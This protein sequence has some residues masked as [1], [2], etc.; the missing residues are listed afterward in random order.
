[1]KIDLAT[2]TNADMLSTINQ[3]FEDIE[4][5][6]QNNVLYR[7]NPPGETN[8]VNNDLDV[9]GS[10]VFNVDNI[11][12]QSLTLGGVDIDS[13]DFE[14]LVTT[15]AQNLRVTSGPITPI[16][17]D[18]NGKF[19]SFDPT[20]NP[21]LSS[22]TG[23]DPA[24][25]ADLATS[26]GGSNVGF[27]QT[28][29]GAVAR[30]VLSKEK[31]VVSVKDFGAVG[32]NVANDSTA[33]TDATAN[34]DVVIVPTGTYKYTADYFS[35]ENLSSAPASAVLK[36]TIINDAFVRGRDSKAIGVK[37]N[38]RLDLTYTGA[39]PR[40]VVATQI[41]SGRM[42]PAPVSMA[43]PAGSIDLMVHWYGDWGLDWYRQ[44]TGIGSKPFD[45]WYDGSWNWDTN[46]TS[47]PE[48]G[49][50]DPQ[51]ASVMGHY[52]NDDR[53]ALEWQAYWLREA[54]IKVVCPVS[55]NLVPSTFFN[56]NDRDY[57]IWNL[58]ETNNMKGMSYI[59][60]G[61]TTDF[62]DPDGPVTASIPQITSQWNNLIYQLAATYTNNY[63]W[64]YNNKRYFTIYA[65]NMERLR[66]LFDPGG[67]SV[68][69]Q[70]FLTGF[71]AGLNT[72]GYDG[73]AVIANTAV[74][75]ATMNRA[76]LLAAG[77]F[78][79]DSPYAGTNDSTT[80]GATTYSDIVNNYAPP[81]SGK[82]INIST[83]LKLV[84]PLPDNPT[85][86]YPGSTPA[87][88]R[89]LL[90]KAYRHVQK[91]T[92]LPQIVTISNVSEWAEQGPG[93]HPNTQDGWGYLDAIRQAVS[94][95]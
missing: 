30:T 1:M 25:R 70:A 36:S 19:V 38:H 62:T 20:G 48:H 42:G 77:V 29:T 68:N 56:A 11:S 2:V 22:G 54:G 28:G 5:E 91:N 44:Q 46:N 23:N 15:Q 45:S 31:D 4:N 16:G 60:W 53:N 66:Q 10:N 86:N 43:S 69:L 64:K 88:F 73:L 17:N 55:F 32:D 6:F 24:L 12:A 63:V 65:W 8:T 84:R 75:D 80:G 71:V 40:N 93:L 52:R 50:Y 82:V 18:R 41:T 83:A 85:Y 49:V 81:T 72:L 37:F 13:D 90:I 34:S 7:N 47:T 58:L 61:R 14:N 3:N 76:A 87:L 78:H 35:V 94:S 51:R 33:F 67:G 21:I 95:A 74:A 79:M 92:S 57:W 27:I 39:Y 9:N 89:K 26:T 59:P